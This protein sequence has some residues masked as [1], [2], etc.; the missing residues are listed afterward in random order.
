MSQRSLNDSLLGGRQ[1]RYGV[2]LGSRTTG[3]ATNNTVRSDKPVEDR[4][5]TH[6]PCGRQA[7]VVY[8]DLVLF[9]RGSR[10]SN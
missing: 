9:D 4:C 7:A 3:A 2:S 10:A 6:G 1:Q 5:A 8:V